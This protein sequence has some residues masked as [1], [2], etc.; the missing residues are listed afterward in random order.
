MLRIVLYNIKRVNAVAERI[1]MSAPDITEK[2]VRSVAEV[3]RSGPLTL[4]PKT[5]EFEQIVA[6]CEKIYGQAFK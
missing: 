6:S 4:G 5:E 2:D 3:V 1:S